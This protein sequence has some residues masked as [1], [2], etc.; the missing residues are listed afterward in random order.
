M[1]ERP[2][3]PTDEND[4]P[5]VVRR[6]RPAARTNPA[7]RRWALGALATL[8]VVVLIG[9]GGALYGLWS[10]ASIDRVDLDLAAREDADPQNFLVVGSDSRDGISEDDPGAGGMLG[11]DAPAGRRADS[12][13]V[14]RI[15][16]DSDR[17]DLLSVPRDLWV[18]ITGSGEEQRINAAYAESAQTVVDTVQDVLGIP[19][20]HFVEVDFGGF[21]SLID[22]LGGV[23]MYFDAP[24]RDRNSGLS[25]ADAGCHVLDGTS[26]LAFARARHLQWSDGVDWNDDPT[27]DLGRMTRQQL[28]T[29]AALEKAQ[30][31]GL[32]DVGRLRGLIDAGMDSVRLDDTLGAGDLIGLGGRLA[33]LDPDRMQ[34]H[35]LPV[36]AE[37]TSG[38]AAIV[39][40]DESAAQP[41]L[42]LF[43]GV[44]DAAPV[45]TTT[46]PPPTPSQ[47]TV[48][49]LNGSG[50]D[51]EARR[52]LF[53]MS[54]E[55]GFG[56]GG[57]ETADPTA[58]TV[59]AHPPDSEAMA[60][61]VAAW[62]EPDAEFVVDED[63][64][65][66]RVRVTLGADFESV[67]E[68]LDEPAP[69][70]T[71]TTAAAPVD[72]TP[73]AAD[74]SVEDDPEVVTA[75]TL[76]GWRPGQPPEGVS[77]P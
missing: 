20:H 23:P 47:V 55:G 34:T 65:P 26:G 27:G 21:S 38:G 51:G 29:R 69:S 1:A 62:I 28:L 59:I 46:A 77:C 4:P 40:L 70:T 22:S 17:V 10:F 2:V 37:R 66:A 31:L 30:T 68:P 9:V 6:P 73:P 71:T 50:V 8:G 12:L 61:L 49:V 15:D 32:G 43:R 57:V 52:V 33:E 60:E 75:T 72:Q 63:L 7:R 42:E 14:A 56:E 54:S 35:G 48:D 24:V 39:T 41:V 45:T 18:P 3:D 16:P 53:V 5:R 36:V 44:T 64:E 19:I 25:V 76:P 74:G 11:A 67:S 13:M 58:R